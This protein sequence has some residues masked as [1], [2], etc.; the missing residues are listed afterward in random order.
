MG[1]KEMIQFLEASSLWSIDISS[2]LN[3]S[4]P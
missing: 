1:T 2:D 3:L 4:F